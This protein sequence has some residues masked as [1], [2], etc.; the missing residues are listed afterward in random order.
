MT[1]AKPGASM[2]TYTMKPLGCDPQRGYPQHEVKLSPGDIV[3][4]YTDGIS[5]AMS[6]D[7]DLYGVDAMRRCLS[8]GPAKLEPLAAALLDDVKKF[9]TG[10]LQ[11]DDVCLVGFARAMR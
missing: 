2:M 5:E 9:S 1:H 8:N 6:A 11:S 10:R 4:L 3:L 7:G